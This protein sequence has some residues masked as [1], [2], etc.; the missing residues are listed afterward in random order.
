[1]CP[2]CHFVIQSTLMQLWFQGNL[3]LLPTISW[4]SQSSLLLQ[5]IKA[6]EFFI[7]AVDALVVSRN[8]VSLCPLNHSSLSHLSLGQ[9]LGGEGE[10]THFPSDSYPITYQGT[11]PLFIT[12]YICANSL[13]F[14]C[15]RENC[16]VSFD[17]TPNAVSYDKQL[18]IWQEQSVWLIHSLNPFRPSRVWNNQVM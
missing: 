17:S 1:M 4:P 14:I 15:G 10:C 18:Q 7:S 5:Y 2:L 11:P 8:S 16:Q 9:G 3:L 6:V 12:P 13:L